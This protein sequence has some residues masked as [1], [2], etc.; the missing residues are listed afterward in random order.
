MFRGLTM[1][2]QTQTGELP[3]WRRRLN[4]R[5]EHER[6][7]RVQ[8]DLQDLLATPSSTSNC[9]RPEVRGHPAY[10]SAQ[11]A[12]SLGESSEDDN[13]PATDDDHCLGERRLVGGLG[14]LR[15]RR[16]RATPAAGRRM[17][18]SRSEDSASEK[19]R[20]KSF[21]DASTQCQ[22]SELGFCASTEAVAQPSADPTWALEQGWAD[23]SAGR[24]DAI[25][26][27]SCIEASD[28]TSTPQAADG[29]SK[30]GFCASTEALMQPAADTTS[31]VQGGEGTAATVAGGACERTAEQQR[32]EYDMTTAEE[33]PNTSKGGSAVPEIR[34]G[35][36]ARRI[37]RQSR[38]HLP[39][40][41]PEHGSAVPESRGGARAASPQLPGGSAVPESC[42]QIGLEVCRRR[43][44]S[45]RRRQSKTRGGGVG[46]LDVSCIL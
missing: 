7:R 43:V 42:G 19:G 4:E 28:L 20:Q 36:R 16:P 23:N 14:E 5:R 31:A 29:C 40:P 15:R 1:D 30:S 13:R 21:A 27:F 41:G 45:T 6:A 37:K 10:E 34:G 22:R 46:S 18:D 3:D 33:R 12:G 26:C 38:D 8:E 39:P 35:S 11:R 9:G 44:S 17:R 25:S 24:P 2:L 32:D